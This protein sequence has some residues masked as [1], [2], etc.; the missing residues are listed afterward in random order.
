MQNAGGERAQE[1]LTGVP[2][3]TKVTG[4]HSKYRT[5]AIPPCMCLRTSKGAKV[6]LQERK[7]LRGGTGC[8][9]N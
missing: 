2:V 8:E 1:S 6:S 4:G 5:E 3:N 7:A 9:L